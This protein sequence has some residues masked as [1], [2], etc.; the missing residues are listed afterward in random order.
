MT[1]ADAPA[2][3]FRAGFSHALWFVFL[4]IP[5]ILAMCWT[6]AAPMSVVVERVAGVSNAID[7][8]EQLTRGQFSHVLRTIILA[9]IIVV[10]LLSASFGIGVVGA[11]VGLGQ[12]VTDFLGQWVWLLAMPVVSVASGI[13]Y[14]DLRIR[15]EAYD[16]EQ[17][18]QTLEDSAPTPA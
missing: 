16:I 2:G 17:L 3:Q 10:V 9:W 4:V 6:F 14:F 11:L 15:T 5:G 13:L 1:V 18:T 7:R 8:S 12:H